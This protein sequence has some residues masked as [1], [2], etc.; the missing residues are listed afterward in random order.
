MKL[1]DLITSYKDL[2]PNPRS[3]TQ[4]LSRIVAAGEPAGSGKF[5]SG[6]GG[7]EP[8]SGKLQPLDTVRIFGRYELCAVCHG[9]RRGAPSGAL[10]KFRGRPHLRDAIYQAGGENGGSVGAKPCSFSGAMPDARQRF[11]AFVA[12]GAGG[13]P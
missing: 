7:R 13:R 12:R 6:C 4:K 2:L 10:P 1:T 5:Q 9:A 3:V 8:G 11:S